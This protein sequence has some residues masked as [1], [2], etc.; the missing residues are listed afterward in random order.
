MK[1]L[2]INNYYLHLFYILNLIK[3]FC[4]ILKFIKIFDFKIKIKYH[5]LQKI[6]TKFEQSLTKKLIKY[7]S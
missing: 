2:S 6:K 1:Q 7:L 4:F 3:F 5:N